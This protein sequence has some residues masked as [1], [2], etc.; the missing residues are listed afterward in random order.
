MG[1]VGK[2][3]IG[4]EVCRGKGVCNSTRQRK[5]DST[6]SPLVIIAF[7]GVG[8]DSQV[9]LEEEFVVISINF[10]SRVVAQS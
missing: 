6:W 4:I 8:P 3:K 5:T 10:L 9:I 7:K 2:K 1:F